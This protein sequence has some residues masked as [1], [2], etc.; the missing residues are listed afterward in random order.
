[1]TWSS[2]VLRGL[3]CV[4]VGVWCRDVVDCDDERQFEV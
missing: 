3:G 2:V 1:V 4:C